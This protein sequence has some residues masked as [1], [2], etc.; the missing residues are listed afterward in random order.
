[1]ENKCYVYE[2]V[3]YGHPDKLADIIADAL[4]DE[5]IRQDANSRCGIEVMVK[6][7]NV[8]L[9][10][11]VSSNGSVDYDS[12]VRGVFEEIQYP[13]NHHLSS[14]EIKI[15]NLIGKQSNE[16]SKGVDKSDSDEIGSGD[17]GVVWGFASNDTVEYMPIGS[18]FARDLWKKIIE[19]KDLGPDIKTQVSVKSSGEIKEIV[20][21]TM[22]QCE[23]DKVHFYVDEKIKELI[24]TKYAEHIS[25]KFDVVINL[26]GEWYIGGPVSDCGIT[27]R[28]LVVDFYGASC[29]I[30]GGNLSGKDCSKVDRSGAYLAR[31]IAKNIVASGLADAAKVELGFI[32]S[33]PTPSA[34]DIELKNGKVEVDKIIEWIET[35]MDLSVKHIIDKF[36]NV[37]FK[38]TSKNGHFGVNTY[39][40][41]QLDLIDG[42]SSLLKK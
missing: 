37:L 39:P 6:D 2:G 20:V 7:N 8:I 16:I 17:Q 38:E 22:H 40:W 28:K 24:E 12:I 9:G 26:N 18:Q 41:E 3:S 4:V 13:S 25:D 35:N 15:T 14:S 10:G 1:M 42:F 29:P 33:K 31:Y 27:G 30:G 34:I 32:I 23:L 36:R 11:E 21:S 5:F 19:I